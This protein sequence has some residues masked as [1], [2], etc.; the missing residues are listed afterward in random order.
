MLRKIGQGGTSRQHQN[1]SRRRAVYN[2]TRRPSRESVCAQRRRAP[3]SPG[4][5]QTGTS[6]RLIL[7]FSL[8]STIRVRNL[9]RELT[10][11]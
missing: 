3:F 5:P 7:S 11:V 2:G 1:R 9:F 8:D 4:A 6:K 10:A